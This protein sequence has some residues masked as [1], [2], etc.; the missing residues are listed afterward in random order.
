[1]VVEANELHPPIAQ[2]KPMAVKR[3][4]PAAK[5][6][7]NIKG[8]VSSHSVADKV[9][10][11]IKIDPSVTVEQ[12]ESIVRSAVAQQ[13]RPLQKELKAYKEKVMLRDIAGGLGF[14]FGLFGVAAS[15]ASRRQQE[16]KNA[17]VS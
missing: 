7:V 14:I 10:E 16:V 5:F 3:S 4:T 13:I 2:S 6:D 15:M 1:M 9:S 17:T 12:L 8:A 11:V